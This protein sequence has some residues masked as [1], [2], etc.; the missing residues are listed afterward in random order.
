MNFNDF[1]YKRID[2]DLVK[3]EGQELLE[4][5]KNAESFGEA[6]RIFSD[7]NESAKEAMTMRTLCSIRHSINTEDKFYE[8]ETEFWDE[9]SPLL[10]QTYIDFNNAV[11]DSKYREQLESIYPK[12]FFLLAE[13]A[14]RVFSEKIIE[15]MQEE[16]KLTT[17]Y[18][19]LIASAKLQFDGKELTLAQMG[20]YLQSTDRSVRKAAAE[21][22]WG[23]LKEHEQEF[24]ELYDKLVKLRSNMAKKLGFE[25][26]TDM[27]YVAMNRFDYNQEMVA[28]YR[29]QV[30]DEV[31][32]LVSKLQKRQANRLNL[33][34]LKYYDTSLKFLDGNANP[35]G[36]AEYILNQG[37]EMYHEL[38]KETAEFIDLMI[39]SNLMDV[40]AK[41]G[42]QSGG[43]MTFLS[44][45][46]VPFIF[47]NFNGTSG[48]V[49]VL[50]HEAGHAFQGY[51]SRNIV[52][53][54]CIMPTME[55]CEIHSMSMEFLTWPYMEK[56]FGDKADKYRF[57]HLAESLSF[58][59]YGVLVDHYQHEV[60]NNP[61]MSIEERKATWK[62]LDNLYRPDLD[63][64]DNDFLEKGTW[65]FRQ[66]HIF[67]SPFYYIDYTL[68][69]VCAFQFWKRKFVNNDA[70]V[71]YDYLRIC[72]IGGT[73]TFTEIV[74]EANLISPF[75][76]GC[77]KSV[78]ND[79]DN[80]L[81]SIDD[82][83]L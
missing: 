74:K 16:N 72:E 62:K 9:K 75:E 17:Q 18:M 34:T 59:P 5:F 77:L 22:S 25:T 36:D 60:Y 65:W 81:E 37:R 47:S 39:D 6:N 54:D 58:L 40:L 44:T 69:Q 63:F 24:D 71:W 27:A 20:P 32:P 73:K 45:Y 64:E 28:N 7:F 42:K 51:Q 2:I 41:P 56:F 13:N 52:L 48:D 38:S 68:A 79:I 15:D 10:Q 57:S 3:K 67:N 53:D 30:L 19:K 8:E 23:F 26:Y 66:N 29:Q 50:T 12:T 61:E 31:V 49:D 80:Y 35:I 82:T 70:N 14:R 33:E 1:E 11:L 76:D 43:Y 46:K 21:T 4:Q 78:V 55:S 83:A